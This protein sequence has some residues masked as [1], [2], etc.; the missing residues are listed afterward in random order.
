M[1]GKSVTHRL[2]GANYTVVKFFGSVAIVQLA[3]P[4]TWAFRGVS[5]TIDKHVCS[6]DNLT[7]K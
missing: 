3:Q 6:I 5:L 7:S 4:E 1:T 2:T